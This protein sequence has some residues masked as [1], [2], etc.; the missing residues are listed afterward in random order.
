M[1]GYNIVAILIY[2][3]LNSPP[4]H[5][6]L[7]TAQS[8]SW[9]ILR[10]AVGKP[11]KETVD[12]PESRTTA[13][14]SPE[15][16]PGVEGLGRK[17]YASGLPLLIVGHMLITTAAPLITAVLVT[18]QYPTDT[19]PSIWGQISHWATR[20]RTTAPLIF[21]YLCI[22]IYLHPDLE[23]QHNE[24]AEAFA[25]RR[26]TYDTEHPGVHKVSPYGTAVLVACFG[27][28]LVNALGLDNVNL[29]LEY[30]RTEYI[31]TERGP[32][33]RSLEMLRVAIVFGFVANLG[34][35]WL[36]GR[37]IQL[38]TCKRRRGV[39]RG[40][41]TICDAEVWVS[42]VTIFVLGG[43]LF[44]GFVGG[45]LVWKAFLELESVQN[46]CVQNLW[47]VDLVYYL[48]PVVLNLW[49]IMAKRAGGAKRT[50]DP[51]RC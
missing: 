6:R 38:G 27:D 33:I 29:M 47:Q 32:L 42:I 43:H 36:L 5:H 39:P 9:T 11:P 24:T 25:Q 16:Q 14:P 37:G 35:L 10:R 50:E 8:A 7:K 13:L 15:E 26:H 49:R 21:I 1:V 48:L 28:Q 23:K 20:P 4:L 12:T 19:G 46:Y 30:A 17:F 3:L 34:I 51:Q 40:T 41:L 18:R 44:L 2:L 31:V 22:R 45:W